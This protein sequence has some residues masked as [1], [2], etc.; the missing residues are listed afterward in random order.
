MVWKVHY[1]EI[2]L[3]SRRPDLSGFLRY[4]NSVIKCYIAEDLSGYRGL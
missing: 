2:S 4:K 1:N 3:S